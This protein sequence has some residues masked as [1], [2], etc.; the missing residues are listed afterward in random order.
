MTLNDS[1]LA[2]IASANPA[3]PTL[4]RADWEVAQAE[5][6]WQRIIAASPV[7][8]PSKPRGGRLPRIAVAVAAVCAGASVAVALTDNGRT[9]VATRS[10]RQA[11]ASPVAPRV[12]AL[13]SHHRSRSPVQYSRARHLSSH[14]T[15][16]SPHT[17]GVI[18]DGSSKRSPAQPSTVDSA[19]RTPVPAT[20][21]RNTSVSTP[22]APPP[23]RK[24]RKSATTTATKTTTTAPPAAVTVPG[25]GIAAGG[26]VLPSPSK[27][28]HP[29]Q[30]Q[31]SAGA[32]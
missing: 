6:I 27:G 24:A 30:K 23:P 9:R 28:S 29:R 12:G 18:G 4:P 13:R 32:P 2:E 5:R 17:S 20:T 1:L 26:T 16:T 8:P 7:D 14:H 3:P 31:P 19:G 10:P 25:G 15:K 21:S 11:E 22:S